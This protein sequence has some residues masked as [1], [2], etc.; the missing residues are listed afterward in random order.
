LS[1]AAALAQTAS[2]TAVRLGPEGSP[3]LWSWTP[4][5]PMNGL[6]AVA[7][8]T[9]ELHSL[10]S[11]PQPRVGLF[12]T[13]GNPA[14]LPDE[15]DREWGQLSVTSASTSGSYRRPLD[16]QDE[17]V[18]ELSVAGWRPVGDHSAAIGRLAVGRTTLA[19]G[20]TAAFLQPYGPNPFFPAD[21]STPRLNRPTVTLEGA[22]GWVLGRWRIGLALGYSVLEDQSVRTPRP[23]IG[24]DAKSGVTVGVVRAHASG[25]ARFGFYGRHLGEAEN[26]TLLPNPRTIR[27]YQLAGY[28]D[29]PYSDF[30]RGGYFRRAD[31]SGWAWG[32]GGA[33]RV[34]AGAQSWAV[35]AEESQTDDRQISTLVPNPPTDRWHASAYRVGAALQRSLRRDMALASAR[36]E[37]TAQRGSADGPELQGKGIDDRASRLLLTADVRTAA[38][39]SP[40][41]GSVLL[42][43]RRD[44]QNVDDAATSLNSVVTGWTTGGGAELDRRVAESARVALSYTI[45]RYVPT[46]TIPSAQGRGVAYQTYIAPALEVAAAGALT[47]SAAFG[48]GFPLWSQRELTIRLWGSALAPTSQSKLPVFLPRGNR[49]AWGVSAAI[50]SR[51]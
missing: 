35:Y 26:V 27:V 45:A 41:A 29:V 49:R 36:A 19:N 9:V 50:A 10:L 34:G 44:A 32:V 48:V 17:S 46:A 24:R 37:F 18:A 21:T 42:L 8:A 13:G 31:R 40:W 2:A 38:T 3:W 14:A 20:T 47:Q 25:R 22:E 51:R 30:T 16:P 15:V 28:A 23:L 5:A 11:L 7:P 39:A 12:W 6:G 4:L 33:G 1:A 43:V